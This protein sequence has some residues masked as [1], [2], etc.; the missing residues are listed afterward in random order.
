[1][2]HPGTPSTVFWGRLGLSNEPMIIPSADATYV[3]IPAF[4]IIDHRN[5]RDSG[6]VCLQA[7][8]AIGTSAPRMMAPIAPQS[9]ARRQ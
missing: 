4:V 7:R 1:M 8:W 9:L 2:A 3:A 6:K 5:P